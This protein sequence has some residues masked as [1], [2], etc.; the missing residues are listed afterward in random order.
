M[1]ST[2]KR[3][4]IIALILVLAS[5]RYL[6]F[7]FVN[8]KF[9]TSSSGHKVSGINA[10]DGT[11]LVV[12]SSTFDI[13]VSGDVTSTLFLKKRISMHLVA[14]L[15]TT[16]FSLSYLASLISFSLNFPKN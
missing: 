4:Y 9:E 7:S 13:D 10:G 6:Q 1:R 5:I 14:S 3:Q 15:V 12:E 8:L 16:I 2:M 11:N